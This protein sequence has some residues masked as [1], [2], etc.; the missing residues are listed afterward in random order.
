M[1]GRK[2]HIVTDTLGLLLVVAV[3]AANVGDRDACR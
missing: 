3:T 2:R 1:P